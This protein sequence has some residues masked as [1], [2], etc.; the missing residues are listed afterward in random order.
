[1]LLA[2]LAEQPLALWAQ[3]RLAEQ[4][5]ALWAEQSLALRAKLLLALLCLVRSPPLLPPARL[6]KALW[7]KLL[8][9]ATLLLALLGTPRFRHLRPRVRRG[10]IRVI[11]LKRSRGSAGGG[12][13]AEKRRGSWVGS[14]RSQRRSLWRAQRRSLWRALRRIVWRALPLPRLPEQGQGRG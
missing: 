2:L 1:M 13:S 4:P 8:L 11:P 14:W 3:Q 5:L 6:V 10:L 7:A 9:W 12:G